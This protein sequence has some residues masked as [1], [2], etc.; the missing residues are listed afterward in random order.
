[1]K[2]TLIAC[3]LGFML[4][5]CAS[6]TEPRRSRY[7]NDITPAARTAFGAS[8]N[9]YRAGRFPEADRAFSIVVSDYPYT[10]LTDKA[11]FYRGEIAF[12]RRDYSGAVAHYRQANSRVESPS[13]ASKAKFK[14][15]LS[16]YR[17]GRNGEAITELESMNRAGTSAILRLRADSVAVRAS[18]RVGSTLPT[19][20]VWYLFIL[21]DYAEGAGQRA[22]EVGNE[23]L[24]T[25]EDALAEVRR[26]ME[27]TT[28]PLTSI[29]ALPLAQMK[30]KKSG[31]YASYKYAYALHTGGRAE[32]A[33]KL[34]KNYLTSY[35]K[36][37]YYSHARLLAMELG[38]EFGAG[39]GISIGTILPLSG[40]YAVYGES[41]LHGIECAIGIFQPCTGPAGMT[42]IVRD[43]VGTPEGAARAVEE[44]AEAG[45]VAI[46]GPLMS[47]SAQAAAMKAQELGVP[48]ISISQRD[49][50]IEVGDFIFRNSV[51]PASEVDAVV[52]YSIGKKMLKR[53][54]ILYPDNKKGSEYERLFTKKAEE[55]GGKI[56]ARHAY[57]PNEMEF[58]VVLKGVG[59]GTP[60]NPLG[61]DAVF[62]PDSFRVVGYIAPTLALS[63]IEGVRLL[64]ISRWDDPGLIE[65]GSKFVDGAIFVDSFYKKAHDAGVISFMKKFKGAYGIDPTLLEALGFDAT[66][67]IVVASQEMGSFHRKTMRDSLTRIAGFRG[68]SGLMGFNPSGDARRKLTLLTVK[69]GAIVPIQ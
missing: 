1:M 67:A 43:S 36:H 23:K 39:A 7:P 29:E 21:D 64:G 37:E 54:F 63:G 44:L 47:N 55:L 57:A 40:R 14:A 41:V 61:Y 49:G 3:L 27:D 15:A 48:M 19:K 69:N 12:A 20:V 34:I 18:D 25:D 24:I 8:Q 45:V 16:L 2:K 9:I 4:V 65:R 59:G 6:G 10:E 32:E 33:S 26:W 17:L 66:R 52:D 62:I 46:V 30:G 60:G 68:V 35:P 50:V 53:F 51:S 28:V 22:A 13:V 5:S 11:L 56:V 31:G 38:G 58:A 42:I